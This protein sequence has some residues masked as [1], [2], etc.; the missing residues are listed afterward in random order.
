[1]YI[2]TNPSTWA[3]CN[4]RSILKQSLI[5]LNS[6]FSFFWTGCRTKVKEHS[7]PYYLPIAGGRIIGFIPFS[8]VLVLWE[9]QSALSRIWTH[10]AMS[11]S[12]DDNHYTMGNWWFFYHHHHHHQGILTAQIPLTL[13]LTIHPNQSSLLAG[14][15][16][17]VYGISTLEGYLMPDPVYIYL[18]LEFHY[19]KRIKNWLIQTEEN[20][21]CLIERRKLYLGL[22]G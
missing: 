7:L 10:V 8:R 14:W 12:Y 15:L 22:M 19:G 3:E 11:I 13:S 9:M 21:V 20:N 4:T 5:G 17:G 2:F 16:V 6:E 18:K 1:M